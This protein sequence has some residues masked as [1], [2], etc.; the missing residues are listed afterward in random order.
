[1]QINPAAFSTSGIKTIGIYATDL[2]GTSGDMQEITIDLQTTS[3]G[4][5]Q[6]PTTPTLVLNPF[7]DS[8][9]T[10]HS[11]GRALTSPTSTRSALIGT[12]DPGATVSLFSVVNGTISGSAVST[13]T[14]GSTGNF[15]IPVGP[16]S[17]DGTYTYL[18]EATNSF[19]TTKSAQFSFTI[20]TQGPTTV[21]TLS[22]NPRDD[23]GVKGDGITAN[24]RPRLIGTADP[25]V[26]VDILDANNNVLVTTTSDASGNYT[27]QLPGVLSNGTIT[28]FARARDLA[29]NIGPTSAPFVLTIDTIAAAPA[30]AG[31]PGGLGHRGAGR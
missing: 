21:P 6:P 30:D 31:A 27:V 23:T 20:K 5:P 1:M 11:R 10:S 25:S 7:D 13:T 3:L 16:S 17:P 15:S 2:S 22:L 9:N 4:L 18:V 26:L 12:T 29:N 19:G 24:T 14:S 28:L 8:S